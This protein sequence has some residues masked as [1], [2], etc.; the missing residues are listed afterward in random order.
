MFEAGACEL[1]KGVVPISYHKFPRYA[2]LA[3]AGFLPTP[4]R[5]CNYQGHRSRSLPTALGFSDKCFREDIL[6]GVVV[7]EV[8]RPAYRARPLAV[9][10]RE[11]VLLVEDMTA[12]RACLR[13][14]LRVNR[15]EDFPVH[16]CLVLQHGEERPPAGI[17]NGHR[18]GMVLLQVLAPELF[19]RDQIVV[20]DECRGEIIQKAVPASEHPAVDAGDE[21]SLLLVVLRRA[22]RAMFL[23]GACAPLSELALRFH[24]LRPRLTV[25]TGIVDD[26][27]VGIRQEVF[28]VQ[29]DTELRPCFLERHPVGNIGCELEGHEV[30]PTSITGY[31]GFRET[32]FAAILHHLLDAEGELLRVSNADAPDFRKEDVRTVEKLDVP[33]VRRSDWVFLRHIVV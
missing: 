9:F 26:F 22:E 1:K 18:K 23:L 16:R 17:R 8:M 27:A 13:G 11:L 19:C 10:Q 31:R 24:K 20:L 3:A 5:L 6:R 32:D 7:A 15:T 33:V 29:V 25:V 4:W 21:P 12:M 2:E 28:E 14:V 30:V